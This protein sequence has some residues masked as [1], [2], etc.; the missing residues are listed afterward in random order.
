VTERSEGDVPVPDEYSKPAHPVL[1]VLRCLLGL[2]PKPRQFCRLLPM[3]WSGRRSGRSLLGRQG[4]DG[5]ARRPLW[6]ASRTR[7][8]DQGPGRINPP[9]LPAMPLAQSAK[10]RE[11]GGRAPEGGGQSLQVR[12]S[13]MNQKSGLARSYGQHQ[14][15]LLSRHDATIAEDSRIRHP[16]SSAICPPF[17]SL[18]AS[19]RLLCRIIYSVA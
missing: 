5:W 7:F 10:S 2:C 17:F 6:A 8:R 19:H 18:P 3:A 14:R 9:G 15:L 13:R 11:F 1:G 16:L 12:E 4:T